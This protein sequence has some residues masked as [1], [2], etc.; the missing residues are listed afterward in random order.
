MDQTE[1]RQ[2]I[3]QQLTEELPFIQWCSV[4]DGEDQIERVDFFLAQ[5]ITKVDVVSFQLLDMEQMWEKLL[6]LSAKSGSGTFSRAWRKKVEVIDWV[7]KK[8]D[9]REIVRSCCFRPEGLLAV[10]EEVVAQ[11]R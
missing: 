8:S 7:T 6:Q 5:M 10:Y 9:G 2:Q 11:S 1:L 3:E 4:A